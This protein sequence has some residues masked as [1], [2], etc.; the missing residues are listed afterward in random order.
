[1]QNTSHQLE[2]IDF[3]EYLDYDKMLK[4]FVFDKQISDGVGV[5]L[6][7]G[8]NIEKLNKDGLIGL[9]HAIYKKWPL[10]A[11]KAFLAHA[12]KRAIQAMHYQRIYK[13]TPSRSVLEADQKCIDELHL[14]DEYL[15]DKP[16]KQEPQTAHVKITKTIKTTKQRTEKL[17]T[18]PKNE[19]SAK[20][21]T[22]SLEELIK[23]AI[24]VGVPQGNIDKHKNKPTGLAKMNISNMIRARVKK[25]D[26]NPK[27]AG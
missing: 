4:H 21:A 2:E 1:M 16:E 6:R 27:V 14:S 26:V 9:L 5:L 12:A 10:N 18:K 20:V 11:N 23:W 8:Q 24:E 15:E 25:L 22:M 7:V 13:T 19:F 17:M 3:E